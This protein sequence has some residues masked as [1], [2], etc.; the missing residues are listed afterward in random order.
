MSV[1]FKVDFMPLWCCSQHVPLQCSSRHVPLQCSQLFDYAHCYASLWRL[2]PMAL[3]QQHKI[4]EASTG[5]AHCNSVVHV[6][7]KR[8]SL[9]FGLSAV[10][11]VLD[12]PVGQA[13]QAT[14]RWH[15]HE[16]F[17]QS[18]SYP[19]S[20]RAAV[21]AGLRKAGHGHGHAFNGDATTG[22]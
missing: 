18:S 7:Q 2:R 4:F 14:E 20:G 13:L 1:F 10:V 6:M 3:R 15:S 17:L 12:L 22:R 8:E 16:A 5:T 21:I 11:G 9:P 19:E